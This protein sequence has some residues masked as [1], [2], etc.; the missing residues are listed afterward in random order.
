MRARE[1]AATRGEAVGSPQTGQAPVRTLGSFQSEGKPLGTSLQEPGMVLC[2]LKGW[3]WPEVDG[4][5]TKVEPCAE[6]RTRG[7]GSLDEQGRGVG[8][9]GHVFETRWT[10]PLM[11]RPHGAVRGR[12]IAD[13]SWP[14]GCFPVTFLS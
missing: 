14:L 7:H 4:N 10:E 12:G 3:F 13:D 6:G 11:N 5:G 8:R 2:T 1:A 9:H